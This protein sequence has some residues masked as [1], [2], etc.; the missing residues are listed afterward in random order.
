M[1]RACEGLQGMRARVSTKN[2]LEWPC[3]GCTTGVH[4]GGGWRKRYI[5]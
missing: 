1:K 4:V 3:C 2:D 5:K